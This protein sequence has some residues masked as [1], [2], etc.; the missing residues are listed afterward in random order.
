MLPE[1]M[2]TAG[3]ASYQR[4]VAASFV[5]PTSFFSVVIVLVGSRPICHQIVD[6]IT[7]TNNRG[8][9]VRCYHCTHPT[10]APRA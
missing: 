3:L 10:A 7:D 9:A 4:R 8:L 1:A 6:R 5:R 2:L